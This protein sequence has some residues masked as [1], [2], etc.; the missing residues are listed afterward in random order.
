MKYHIKLFVSLIK[1]SW[2]LA[3]ALCLSHCRSP[4]KTIIHEAPATS[5]LQKVQKIDTPT[6]KKIS[7]FHH[8]ICQRKSILCPVQDSI[9]LRYNKE[10]KALSQVVHYLDRTKADVDSVVYE[11]HQCD[12]LPNWKIYEL[13][14]DQKQFNA[15]AEHIFDADCRILE[16]YFYMDSK[17]G[18]KYDKKKLHQYDSIGQHIGYI[19]YDDKNREVESLL[20]QYLNAPKR[21]VK[22]TTRHLSN[23]N[24]NGTFVDTMSYNSQGQLTH[25]IKRTDWK[26]KK[27]YDKLPRCFDCTMKYTYDTL[28]KLRKTHIQNDLKKNSM[29]IT[30]KYEGKWIQQKQLISGLDTITYDYQYQRNQFGHLMEK[31]VWKNG[32]IDSLETRKLEY[33]SQNDE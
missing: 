30:K 5:D 12:T 6:I 31:S 8:D 10:E 15:R 32:K 11:Y 16:E 19:E 22:K 13:G 28:G 29:T 23:G 17:W 21:V 14:T 2:L 7:I 27:Y 4:K 24:Y 26:N 18:T 1:L 3:V 33:Y 25:W 20:I 9:I